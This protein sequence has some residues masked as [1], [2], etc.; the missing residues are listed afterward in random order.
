MK[1]IKAAILI[2]IAGNTVFAVYNFNTR[3]GVSF[4]YIVAN[5]FMLWGF[6]V[7]PVTKPV[8]PK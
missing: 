2:A 3:P 6:P 8:T 5:L 4:W 7:K 1:T